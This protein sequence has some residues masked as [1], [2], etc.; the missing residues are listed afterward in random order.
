LVVSR[1]TTTR[2]ASRATEALVARPCNLAATVARVKD[3]LPPGL[4][5]EGE[6]IAALEHEL[7]RNRPGRR[8][9]SLVMLEVDRFQPSD[10]TRAP[11][12]TRE[13]V[14]REVAAFVRERSREIDVVAC[15]HDDRLAIILP[16]IEPD[17]AASFAET[18]RKAI[19]HHPFGPGGLHVTA[20]LGVSP[21]APYHAPGGE[22]IEKVRA[23]LQRASRL[24]N[25]VV[26][27]EPED[28][29]VVGIRAPEHRDRRACLVV[30]EGTKRG[31]KYDIGRRETTIGRTTDTDIEVSDDS[32]SPI[33]ATITADATGVRIRDDGS[34]HGTRVNGV[35]IREAFLDNGDVIVMGDHSFKLLLGEDIDTMYHEELYRLSTVDSLTQLFNRRYFTDVLG[36]ELSRARRYDR[37]LALVMLDIDGF[38]ACNDAFGPSTGDD[39]LRRLAQLVRQRSRGV[40]AVARYGGDQLVVLLP[41]HELDAAVEHAEALRTLVE[42]TRFELDGRLIP[43]TISLGVAELAPDIVD[44]DDLVRIVEARLARAK[45]L[46]R[47]RVVSSDAGAVTD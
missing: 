31:R 36:R 23:R 38:A 16:E 41:E 18:I 29:V 2:R 39:V 15:C 9:L 44:A 34:T 30:I 27:S 33:H 25:C 35:I 32:V 10:S 11:R 5:D 26:S 12:P 43:L 4:L 37:P 8:S 46:G 40:D 42:R 13:Q 28:C 1:P 21:L 17:F 19:E 14:L 20:S 3:V 47:N 7:P 24:G 6:L 45:A 22:L